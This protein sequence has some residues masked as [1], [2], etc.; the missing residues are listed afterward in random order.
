MSNKNYSAVLDLI[1]EKKPDILILEEINNKWIDSLPE[2]ND[3]KYKK[4]QTREDNFGIGLYSNIEI[5]DSKL[6]Y[7]GEFEVP[8]IVAN[9]QVNSRQFTFIATHPLLPVSQE[10]FALRNNQ[11]EV[12]E[13]NSNDFANIYVVIK[14]LHNYFCTSK[15][16]IQV[17]GTHMHSF[18]NISI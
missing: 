1:K 14:K 15:E 8:S 16:C 17:P 9:M 12:I 6:E 10:Y 4:V 2:L 7:F 3:F 13:Q 5:I 11:L 18:E